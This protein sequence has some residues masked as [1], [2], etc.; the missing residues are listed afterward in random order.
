[1]TATNLELYVNVNMSRISESVKTKNLN[2]K[3]ILDFADK[4]KSSILIFSHD[5]TF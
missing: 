2:L 4:C 1:M 5:V 3:K